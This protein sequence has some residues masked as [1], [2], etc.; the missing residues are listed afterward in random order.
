MKIR[1]Y[2][3]LLEDFKRIV[4]GELLLRLK[5]CCVC[6][7]MDTFEIAL[8]SQSYGTTQFKALCLFEKIIA[9]AFRFLLLLDFLEGF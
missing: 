1:C 6:D 3:Y 7:S 5:V 2:G 4:K 8:I 9:S